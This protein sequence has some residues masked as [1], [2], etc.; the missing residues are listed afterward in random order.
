MVFDC[1]Y[2]LSKIFN[3]VLHYK[4]TA[5]NFKNEIEGAKLV[6]TIGYH[7]D[8]LTNEN[9]D[10]LMIENMTCHYLPDDMGMHF[11]NLNHIDVTNTGLKVLTKNNMKMFPHLKYLYIRRNPIKHL[12]SNLFQHNQELQFINFSDN[13]IK[14]INA[15]V[16]DDISSLISVNLERNV[17]IDMSTYND[18]AALKAQIMIKCV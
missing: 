11:P 13:K 5:N 2:K 17:C 9:V 7:K 12:L 10:V 18:I 8:S 4:C 14:I 3:R 16:F 15:D 1:E 6:N